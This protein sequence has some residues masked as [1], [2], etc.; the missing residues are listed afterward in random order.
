M[1]ATL[2]VLLGAVVVAVATHPAVAPAQSTALPDVPS[3]RTPASPAFVLLGVSPTD[4]Y[5]PRTPADFAF[6]A[7][8]RAG[9]A[10]SIPKDLA[11]EASPYWLRSHPELRWRDDTV[12]TLGQSLARSTGLSFATT[13]LDAE[14]EPRTG[15]AVGLRTSLLSGRL[16]DSTRARLRRVEDAAH[17]QG[18]IFFQTRKRERELLNRALIDSI[19]TIDALTAGNLARRDSLREAARAHFAPL[20]AAFDTEIETDPEYRR[21][22]EAVRKRVTD[23]ALQREG[24]FWDVAGG[25]VWQFAGERWDGG[26][27]TKWGAWT[28]L[29]YEGAV[30]GRWSPVITARYVRNDLVADRSGAVDIGGRLLRSAD[31]YGVSVEYVNRRLVGSVPADAARNQYRLTG[32]VEYRVAADAWLLASFGRAYDAPERRG[33]LV[34]QLG[35]SLAFSRDRYKADAN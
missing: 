34:A 18:Q 20:V 14:G 12:R 33:N 32:M 5:K 7:L 9:D 22:I 24:F 13:A 6:T 17:A 31:Q 28:T 8:S 27:L 16:T 4:V 26:D 29:A 10:T 3:L 19:R 25:A 21:L 35:L 2:R 15:V 1:T 23:F 11:I 30:L